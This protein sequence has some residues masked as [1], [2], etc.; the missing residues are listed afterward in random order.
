MSSFPCRSG[1][2]LAAAV[3]VACVFG[4]A[5]WRAVAGEK[6]R[7]Q[8]ASWRAHPVSLH[9]AT[10]TS[11]YWKMTQCY[12]GSMPQPCVE[13]GCYG[14]PIPGLAIPVTASSRG[15]LD[16]AF[17]G[18][19]ENTAPLGA[20]YTLVFVDG[21]PVVDAAGANP[22]EVAGTPPAVR[23]VVQRLEHLRQANRGRRAPGGDPRAVRCLGDGVVYSGTLRVQV[24]AE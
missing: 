9:F 7:A 3:L 14:P 8:P 21:K 2:T 12:P 18:L 6:P 13:P 4:A 22:L 20:T 24:L 17:S 15:V 19:V 23:P 16:I 1:W 10:T 11:T 5:A